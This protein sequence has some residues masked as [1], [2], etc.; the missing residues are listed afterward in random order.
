MK[1]N[2]LAVLVSIIVLSALT[3]CGAKVPEELVGTWNAVEMESNGMTA[4]YAEYAA[5]AE[6]QGMDPTMQIIIS[7]NGSISMNMGGELGTAKFIGANGKYYLQDD[8][9][10]YELVLENNQIRFTEPNTQTI[11]VFGK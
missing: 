4:T 3:G 11:I 7:D 2:L 5:L 1:K 8:V 9:D 6:A 10:K